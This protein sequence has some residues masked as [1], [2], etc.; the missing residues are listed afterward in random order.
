MDVRWILGDSVLHISGKGV[1][2][3]EMG[4]CSSAQLK[5]YRT[6][7]DSTVSLPSHSEC[8]AKLAELLVR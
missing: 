1:P 3:Q 7:L 4:S 5:A 6:V 2:L 8:F